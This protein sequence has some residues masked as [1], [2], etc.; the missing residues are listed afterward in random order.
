MPPSVVGVADLRD[1]S[2]SNKSKS[3]ANS[4]V[5]ALVSTRFIDI[6]NGKGD[7]VGAVRVANSNVIQ[8]WLFI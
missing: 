7:G 2:R 6:V 5:L 3:R 4:A 8:L 1:A